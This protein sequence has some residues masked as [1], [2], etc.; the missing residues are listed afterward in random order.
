[1]KCIGA[2]LLF[3]LHAVM[4]NSQIIDVK[5]YTL[6]VDLE[7]ESNQIKVAE[8]INFE[9]LK[10]GAHPVFDLV[11]FKNSG[12]GME[13]D[14]I[15]QDGEILDFTHENDSIRITTRSLEA[16]QELTIYYHGIPQD[17]LIIGQNKYGERTFFGDNWPNRAH[18]W[19]ACVDHPSDKAQIEYYVSSPK[20]YKVI[21]NGELLAVDS[22]N[23]MKDIY[24]YNSHVELPTK[25]MVIGVADF[26]TEQFESVENIPVSGWVYKKQASK[27]IFDLA[28]SPKV[29]EFFINYI[30]PYPFEKLANVQSTTRYGGME[31]AGCIFYDEDALN[32]N[33]SSESLIAHEI[34]HQW[35]G[36]SIT[37]ENWEHIWL[38]EGFATY[39]A[40]LHLENTK[41]VKVFQ[42][43]MES[44]RQ[45]IISY[46][47]NFKTPLVDNNYQDLEDLLNP[48]SYQK[49]AWVLHMMRQQIGDSLFNESIRKYY[50]DFKLRNAN[51]KDFQNVIEEVTG[52]SWT[53][54]FHQ[55]VYSEGHPKIR[56]EVKISNSKI[57]FDV[58]QTDKTFDF[59][60]TV[61]LSLINGQTDFVQLMVSESKQSFTFQTKSKVKSFQLDPNVELLFENVK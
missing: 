37:E 34:A 20:K 18:H 12:T 5:K 25:V 40:N 29:L 53:D 55:W 22:S 42:N 1:M 35:F 28:I 27:S 26:K 21:A 49:G 4:V 7:D 2:T 56:V 59:P 46:N 15:V 52:Y 17:G 13:V 14:S 36:N 45:R 47:K 16:I 33:R 38:S 48:N 30:G 10:S 43:Q 39:F 58:K 3:L 11:Q 61:K 50:N 8:K 31:N 19:I 51:S 9:V 54:F 6:N 60:L 44:D 57:T 24:H 41:G 32:G 23:K